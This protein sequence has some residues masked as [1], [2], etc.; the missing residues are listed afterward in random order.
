VE[1]FFQIHSCLRAFRLSCEISASASSLALQNHNKLNLQIKAARIQEGEPKLVLLMLAHAGEETCG[2]FARARGPH[3]KYSHNVA[4]CATCSLTAIEAG[5]KLAQNGSRWL[6][7][8]KMAQVSD[9]GLLS[10]HMRQVHDS[11]HNLDPGSHGIDSLI[12]NWTSKSSFESFTEVCPLSSGLIP[13][14]Q[15]EN[16]RGEFS[17]LESYP[18]QLGTQRRFSVSPR[19][20]RSLPPCPVPSPCLNLC[21]SVLFACTSAGEW[22]ISDFL[23]PT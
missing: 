22:T 14:L 17:G 19:S 3:S 12:L 6:K 11:V 8:F 18:R 7:M 13:L 21:F 4:R 1:W 9:P 20:P 2:H 10:C 23:L 16:A 5:F 15:S